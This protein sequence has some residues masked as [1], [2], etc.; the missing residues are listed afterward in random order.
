MAVAKA[1]P[2]WGSAL[3]PRE[4]RVRTGWLALEHGQCQ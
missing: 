2:G 1:E 4:S 3:P